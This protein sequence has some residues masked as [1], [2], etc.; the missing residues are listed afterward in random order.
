LALTVATTR[1]L[2][3]RRTVS[4]LLPR[5][6]LSAL[7]RGDEDE[8]VQADAANAVRVKEKV[9]PVS[10]EQE[11]ALSLIRLQ[12]AIDIGC[13][14]ELKGLLV[15]GLKTGSEVRVRLAEATDL[16]VTAVEL[17]W[18]A[19]RE[20]KASGVGFAFEGRAPEPVSAALA[21]AGIENVAATGETR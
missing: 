5:H 20:A 7:P 16:D 13:A 8:D 15:Q 17:L 10:L 1:K 3:R 2:A 21:E 14:E 6:C 4:V 9:L 11:G 18:A 12:G 19:R